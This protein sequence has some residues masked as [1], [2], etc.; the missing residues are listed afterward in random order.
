MTQNYELSSADSIL[1]LF[2]TNKEQRLSFVNDILYQLDNGQIDPLKIHL[3]VKAME[4]IIS[5]LTDRKTYPATA[6]RYVDCL[7]TAAQLHGKAFTYQHAKFTTRE[8]GTVYDFSNCGDSKLNDLQ[9]RFDALKADLDARKN[10][11]K[12]L[13]LPIGGGR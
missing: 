5:R 1:A 9:A 2:E 8:T 13:P 7:L 11:L 12:T 10:F 3:Q 4:E 6:T